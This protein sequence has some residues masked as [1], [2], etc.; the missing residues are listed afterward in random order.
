MASEKVIQV[1][2]GNFEAEV[3]SSSLP[4]LIDFGAT[5]C[6]PCRA[7]A[8]LIDQLADEYEGRAKVAKLDV[9]DSPGTA[10]K[11]GIRSVPTLM[12]IKDGEVVTQQVGALPKARIAALIDR[13]L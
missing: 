4:V 11:Y 10:A 5:W 2:D 13:A 7:V 6:A 3:L 1:N 8:P 9:D 12:V